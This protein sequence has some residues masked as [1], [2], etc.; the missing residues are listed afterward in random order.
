MAL[1]EYDSNSKQDFIFIPKEEEGKG[2]RRLAVASWEM[3]SIKRSI[4]H[5]RG[6]AP[7]RPLE[8]TQQQHNCSYKKAFEMVQSREG[9]RGEEM[10]V[11]MLGTITSMGLIEVLVQ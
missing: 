1:V 9:L 8:T 11:H 2:W 10:V 4:T 3:V 7:L 6:G 5:N